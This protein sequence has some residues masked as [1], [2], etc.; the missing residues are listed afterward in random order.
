MIQKS[1]NPETGVLGA[2]KVSEEDGS[3]TFP[4]SQFV[5]A[6]PAQLDAMREDIWFRSD[7]ADV[8]CR[9][10]GNPHPRIVASDR[11]WLAMHGITEAQG[12]AIIRSKRRKRRQ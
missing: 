8:L 3:D 12:K 5:P 10:E 6:G 1:P 4:N 9:L 7:L 11:E 2:R